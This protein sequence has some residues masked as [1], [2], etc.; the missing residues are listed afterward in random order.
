MIRPCHCVARWR[1]DNWVR[2]PWSSPRSTPRYIRSPQDLQALE[3][4]VKSLGC[5]SLDPLRFIFVQPINLEDLT[6]SW[7]R[8]TSR[9]PLSI[10][11]NTSS[12]HP[13]LWLPKSLCSGV[14]FSHFSAPKHGMA[15]DTELVFYHSPSPWA[16]SCLHN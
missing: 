8:C 7:H 14:L 1:T 6:Y 13:L 15:P 5:G 16:D 9:C 10:P 11:R 3:V 2:G 12:F 4:P